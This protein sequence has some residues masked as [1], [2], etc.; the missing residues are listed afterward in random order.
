MSAQERAFSEKPI[1][2]LLLQLFFPIF[3]SYFVSEIYSMVDSFVVGR[4]IGPSAIGALNAIM[5][6]Q[7]LWVALAV[8]IALGAQTHFSIFLGQEDRAKAKGASRTGY[9]LL[10][11]LFIPLILLGLVFRRPLVAISGAGAQ[12]APLAETYLMWILPGSLFLAL[13]IYKTQLLVALGKGNVALYSTLIGAGLNAVL[14]YIFVFHLHLGVAGTGISTSISQLVAYIFVSRHNQG[15]YKDWQLQNVKPTRSVSALSLVALGLSSFVIEAEDGI[16]VALFNKLLTDTVGE[17]GLVILGLN[18]RLYLFL[19]VITCAMAAAMQPLAS[20]HKGHGNL[21]KVVEVRQ[22]A[23]KLACI[24]AVIVW[25]ILLIWTKPAL[26]LFVSD[27]AII[28][29]AATALHIMISGFPLISIY[30]VSIYYFQAL[31]YAKTSFL[32]AIT[33]QLLIMIP[34]SL[35]L[36]KVFDLGT[37]GIWY[38]YPIADA[39][40]GAISLYLIHREDERI[41]GLKDMPHGA[42]ISQ[43]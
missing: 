14:D 16:L 25:A 42:A 4:A 9:R 11:G 40:A 8:M 23:M 3:L 39:L 17:K 20:Y 30:Y 19:F 21:E 15:V 33:R 35:L 36:V 22:K 31:G 12:M 24:G 28:D 5:P 10:L 6:L 43:I 41:E 32:I 29:E 27:P 1:D 38:S 18:T 26:R 37:M 7:R 34:A 2:Q 13:T